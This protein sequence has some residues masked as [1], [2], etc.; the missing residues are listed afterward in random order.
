MWD[1]RGRI[2]RAWLLA[3]CSAAVHLEALALIWARSAVRRLGRLNAAQAPGPR[4]AARG[5]K[6]SEKSPPRRARP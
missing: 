1:F 3:E 6:F 5:G 4:G 2:A